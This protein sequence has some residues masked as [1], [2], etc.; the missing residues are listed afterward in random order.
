MLHTDKCLRNIREC[1]PGRSP[2]DKV[3]GC[4]VS[5]QSHNIVPAVPCCVYCREQPDSVSWD[6]SKLSFD[7]DLTLQQER[8]REREMRF[9]V[10]IYFCY[11][12]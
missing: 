7:L 10:C 8:E 12:C 11:F 4:Q 9:I 5:L 2:R 6:R 1:V 3:I